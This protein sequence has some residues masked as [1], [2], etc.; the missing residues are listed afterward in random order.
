MT[1]NRGYRVRLES[2][3]TRHRVYVDGR[4]VLEAS[5]DSIA[6]G[7]AGLLTYRTAAEFDNVMVMPKLGP[8]AG[9]NANYNDTAKFTRI[10]VRAS[11]GTICDRYTGNNTG[12]EPSKIG[13]GADGTNCIYSTS[14]ITYMP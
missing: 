7:R 1:L 14:D 2:I 8:L 12:A 9:I 11:S 4:P 6:S 13:S 10:I 5:D 3:G